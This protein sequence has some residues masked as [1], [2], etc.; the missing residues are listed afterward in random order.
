MGKNDIVLFKSMQNLKKTL[1]EKTA[2]LL[3]AIII[4]LFVLYLSCPALRAYLF[5]QNIDPNFVLGFLTIIT[6]VVNIQQSRKDRKLTYNMNIYNSVR[7]NGLAIISKLVAIRQKSEVTL[8]TLKYHR[9]AIKNRQ[10]F[11]DYN[12]TR[13]KKDIDD[14][15]QM[16]AAYADTYFREECEGLN[17]MLIKLSDTASDNIN[18]IN[19]Y[20]INF[21]L[22][23]QGISFKN[24]TLDKIDEI[25]VNAEK[26]NAEINQI[27][28]DMRDKIIEKTNSISDK[29]KSNL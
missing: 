6:L 8:N 24:E 22:I 26:T 4:I 17:E 23:A 3:V 19:N 16:V 12:D 25:I 14:G 13:S 7:D 1:K 10:Y 20:Q 27:T 9:E 18:V 2:E 11:I 5:V 15:F 29:I 28:L 21:Q